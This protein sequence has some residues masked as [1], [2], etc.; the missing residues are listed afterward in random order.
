MLTF[1]AV[2]MRYPEV[3]DVLRNVSFHLEKVKLPF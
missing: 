1:D 3:G 2:N